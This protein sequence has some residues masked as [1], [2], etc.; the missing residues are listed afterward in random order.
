MPNHN[1]KYIMLNF[2]RN[3]DKKTNYV[4]MESFI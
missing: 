1:H 4:I 2:L 3:L